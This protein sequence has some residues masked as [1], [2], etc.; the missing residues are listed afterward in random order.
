M[1]KIMCAFMWFDPMPNRP[2]AGTTT[3]YSFGDHPAQL[4]PNPWGLY[5]MYGNVWEWVQD[6]FGDYPSEPQVD[7]TGPL[8]G[9]K[10]MLRGVCYTMPHHRLRHAADRIISLPVG[11]VLYE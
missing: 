6:W 4:K 8:S 3:A 1:V 7:S 10:R 11:L 9:K 5:D 2:L